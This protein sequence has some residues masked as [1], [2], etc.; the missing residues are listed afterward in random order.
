MSVLSEAARASR[1]PPDVEVEFSRAELV[2]WDDWLPAGVARGWLLSWS[3]DGGGSGGWAS[4]ELAC[5][6]VVL[7]VSRVDCVRLHDRG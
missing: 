4:L 5:A 7:R 3:P 1:L 6:G 2:G